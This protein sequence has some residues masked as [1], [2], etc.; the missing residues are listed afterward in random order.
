MLGGFSGRAAG[1]GYPAV[2]LAEGENECLITAEVPGV[3]KEDVKVSLHNGN[4]TIKAI[5]KSTELPEDGR[6]LRVERPVGEFQRTI[7]LPAKVDA[8]R[9]SAELSNGTLRIILP[10]TQESRQVQIP[11]K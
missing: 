1:I 2:D 9:V 5:R 11:V 4:V 8:D 7:R 6:W 10:K 3:S